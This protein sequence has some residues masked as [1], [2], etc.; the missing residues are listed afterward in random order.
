MKEKVFKLIDEWLK[1]H[2]YP[3]GETV[4]QNDDCVID[5]VSLVSDI[6]DLFYNANQLELMKIAYKY[7]EKGYNEQQL[8]N[9]DDLYKSCESD[10]DNCVD[11]FLDICE[12]GRSRFRDRMNELE[13]EIND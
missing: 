4:H 8:R 7:H 3:C 13:A 5:S 1:E 2:D 10:I 6:A 11:Y 12:D 9:G